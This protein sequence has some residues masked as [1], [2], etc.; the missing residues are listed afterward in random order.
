MSFATAAY[1]R[2][3]F[4]LKTLLL[5]VPKFSVHGIFCFRGKK[6]IN[7]CAD[8]F[9]CGMIGSDL[10]DAADER[11]PEQMNSPLGPKVPRPHTQ[12]QKKYPAEGPDIPPT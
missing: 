2:E 5:A 12:G 3:P 9:R 10:H 4:F 8:G 6:N 11:C 7:Q 1:M